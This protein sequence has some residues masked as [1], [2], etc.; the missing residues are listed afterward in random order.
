MRSLKKPESLKAGDTIALVRPCS[1]LNDQ[2]WVQS[3]KILRDLGFCVVTYP[4]KFPENSFFA[5]SDEARGKELQWALSEPG[6][7]A[8]FCARGG[9][10]SARAIRH[11]SKLK[12]MRPKIIVGY[13]DVTYLLHWMINQMAWVG[14]HGPLVGYLN[15]SRM[16][17]FMKEV[18]SLPK[19]PSKMNLPEAKTLRSGT[20]KPGRL[21][22]GNLSVLEVT[23]PAALPREPI[24]L[25]L[26]EVN[27]NHYEIDRLL[28]KILD[29]GYA[30]FIQGILC[31][32]FLKCGKADSKKF[33]WKIIEGR[34]QKLTKGPILQ[35]IRFGHGVSD[36][37]IFPLG[38]K[39]RIKGKSI[40]LLEEAVRPS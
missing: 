29:A 27:E 26:E 10:G 34:L 35:N 37:R 40:Q 7:K 36:Q 30:P 38:L 2:Q 23:G 24:I 15:S 13:S 33:P 14:F 19:T 1:R 16:K 21:V 5:S 39:V 4:E 12:R 20:S 28:G 6:V 8:I 9:Y 31:G 3:Q 22:G 25:I 32:K 11:F 18:I 17:K